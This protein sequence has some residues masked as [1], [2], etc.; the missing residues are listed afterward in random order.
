MKESSINPFMAHLTGPLIRV[1]TQAIAYSPNVKTA[2]LSVLAYILDRIPS[3]VKPSFPQLQR[4]FVKAL[5][6]APSVVVRTRAADA[7]M[8][9]QPRVD[10]VFTELVTGARS[11]EEEI[12]ASFIFALSNIMKSSSGNSG[13]GLE[14]E[15]RESC[16]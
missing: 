15:A 13:I 6:N 5:S 11:S 14:D 4:M 7:F 9:S 3:H 10:P 8:R 1:A 16:V 2:T 12:A